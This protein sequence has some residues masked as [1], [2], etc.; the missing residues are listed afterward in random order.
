[1]LSEI[2]EIRLARMSS[3]LDESTEGLRL[4]AKSDG[5]TVVVDL[6]SG[7]ELEV[8]EVIEYRNSR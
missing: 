3:R 6:T 7:V 8:G 1:M 2:K 4:V 5:R